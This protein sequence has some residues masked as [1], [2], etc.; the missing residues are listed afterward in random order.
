M[1]ELISYGADVNHVSGS[2]KTP[3]FEVRTADAIRLLLK[4]GADPNKSIDKPGD[5]DDRNSVIDYLMKLNSSC[6]EI[7]LD[8]FLDRDQETNMLIIDFEVFNK[9]LGQFHAW[10]KILRYR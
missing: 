1:I 5:K 3:I 8:E 2:G 4:Y 10:C 7:L 6:P 9:A